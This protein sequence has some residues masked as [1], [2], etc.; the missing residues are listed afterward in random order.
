MHF[1]LLLGRSQRATTWLLIILLGSVGWLAPRAAWATHIRAGDIQSRVDEASGNPNHLLFR[2]TVYRD[3]GGMALQSLAETYIYF[4]D[5]TLLIGTDQDASGRPLM[6][7]TVD[8]AASTVDTEVLY[9][10]FEHTYSGAGS[11]L[12]SF[13]GENRNDGVLNMANSVRTSFYISS[14][15]TINPA[16]GSNHS[17]VLR[18]PAVDKAGLGQVFLHNP[19]A[20]DADGDS[21]SFKLRTC[22]QVVGGN[23]ISLLASKRPLPVDCE[24]YVFPDDQSIA[25]G[26]KQVPY[27]GVP[28]G[29]PTAN[30][31]IRQ[32]VYNG[33]LTWNAPAR[34]G[35]YNIA[36]TVEEWRRTANGIRQIGSVIRDMQIIVVATN[37]VPPTL[38]VLA[39]VDVCVVAGTP[40]TLAVSATDGTGTGPQGAPSPV[41][42]FAYS[43]ILPPA[44][45]T[46]TS[47][48]TTTTGTFRW[49][50]DCSNVANQ[51][52]TVV[53]KAQDQPTKASG[54]PILI[55][56]KTVRITVVGPPPQNVRAQASSSAQGLI[57]LVSWEKYACP[58]ASQL[59]I[60]RREGCFSYTPGLCETGLPAG[61]GYVQVGA[62]PATTTTFAD[63]NAGA[64]LTRGKTYSY[65]VYATF[66]LPSGGASLVS[67]ESCL[68]FSGRSA[69]LTNVD[70]NTT[71]ATNGQFTVKWSQPKADNN[72]AFGAPYGYR[73]SRGL[74]TDPTTFTLVATSTN[75]ADTTYVDRDLNTVAN[76]Y[77]YR[78][79]FFN[80]DRSTGTA[81]DKTETAA[82][83]SSVRTSLV[84]DGLA[85]T[86]TVNWSYRVPWDN[87]KQPTRIYRRNP[88]PG[89]TFTQ[90]GTA[91]PGPVS[92][93]FVDRDPALQRGLQYCYYVQ[94][95]GQYPDFL[96][97]ANQPILTNLLNNSQQVCTILQATP[98]TPVLSLRPTN[99]DSLEA[100]PSFP[101]PSQ[102]YQNNLRW[103]V[104]GSPSGCSTAA[105][106]YRILRSEVAGGPYVALDSTAR[107]D[108]ADRFRMKSA[109]CYVV[110]AVSALGIRSALS[111]AV[112]QDECA[113]FL[114]P[115]IFTPNGDGINDTFR[116][117]TA[118]TV[119]HTRILIFNRWGRKVY[120]GDQDPYI[121]WTGGSST[122]STGGL[123]AGGLYYYLAEVQFADAANTTRT[124]KGWVEVVR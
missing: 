69:R 65:R 20:Y 119:A 68:T 74:G 5:N 44:T 89:S 27:A 105:A 115:N 43:G 86:I 8:A 82:P 47:S 16:Y 109:G 66:A 112:C 23:S 41:T 84:P 63:D 79:T 52:Y 110:Q 19:A 21:L 116:P 32:D 37:N 93:T 61:S 103:T 1:L 122:E 99:C 34:T 71:D 76:Q 40:V 107:L 85:N 111:N 53:F 24:R 123:V 108:Y 94:T 13:V 33:Q 38:T 62:V 83:A 30:A 28:A 75:L 25:A 29:D 81:V 2:L 10:D 101:S 87:T 60:F 15:V 11:Y 117:K 102:R 113:F 56:E 70:I 73:L 92:G 80:T 90:V 106:Y 104:G 120:E 121:N 48:G 100:L 45:F 4:G 46:Q 98:C 12:V 114:L 3:K 22:Q 118:S 49:T 26:A 95:N 78:L 55:D 124:F 96:N 31:I 77:T 9:F 51:P 50:P 35:I 54:A 18:A 14:T 88:A 6:T 67:N 59:L 72:S 17:P 39:D 42:L 58:N 57:S 7:R 36:F 91:M 64:G 97:S